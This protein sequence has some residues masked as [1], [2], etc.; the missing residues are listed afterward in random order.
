MR[1]RA[2]RSASADLRLPVERSGVHHVYHQFV[3]QSQ[4]RDALREHLAAAG[5]ATLVHYPLALHEVEA[6][7]T[8]VTFREA[9]RRAAEAARTI[10]SLPIYPELPADHQQQVIGAILAFR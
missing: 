10:L 5:V 1:S 9:P 8:R 2:N 7:R 3:I 4:R 6:L